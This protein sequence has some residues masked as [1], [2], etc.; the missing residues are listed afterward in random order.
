V[1]WKILLVLLVL[2]M[3]MMMMSGNVQVQCSE[4][5]EGHAYDGETG[6]AWRCI[7]LP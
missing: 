2:V 7:S 1:F 6:G 4:A 5:C 3:M